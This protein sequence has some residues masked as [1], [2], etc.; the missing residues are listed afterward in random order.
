MGIKNAATQAAIKSALKYLEKNPEEN[1]PKLMAWVDKFAGEGPDSFPA[2]RDAVRAVGEV[3]RDERAPGGAELHVTKL[4]VLSR[5][6]EPM[7]VPIG[8]YKMNLSMDTD[9]ALRFVTL[10]NL[11]K[12]AVF[13]IQEGVVRGFREALQ[14]EGFT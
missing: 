5:A 9:L 2:Q 4:T 3:A 10:R 14:R 12:R 8:K 1:L 6:A 13:K 7:P 11:R